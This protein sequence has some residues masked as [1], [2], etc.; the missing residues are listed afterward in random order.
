VDSKKKRVGYLSKMHFEGRLA[1]GPVD[2][3]W[4]PSDPRPDLVQDDPP[5]AKMRAPMAYCASVFERPF[6][7]L[8]T[9]LYRHVFFLTGGN[10]PTLHRYSKKASVTK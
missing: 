8:L 3:V 1:F 7:L 2:D 4:V 9:D 6:S 10:F 5:S